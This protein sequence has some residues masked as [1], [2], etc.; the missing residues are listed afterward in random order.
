MLKNT[1]FKL[2][3]LLTCVICAGFCLWIIGCDDDDDDDDDD[4]G[5]SLS[6]SEQCDLN[7]ALKFYENFYTCDNDYTDCMIVC[8]ANDTGCH[9]SCNTDYTD[10]FTEIFEAGLNCTIKCDGCGA[11]YAGLKII[12]AIQPVIVNIPTGPRTGIREVPS[13][14]IGLF[15]SS[16]SSR[17]P[18]RFI[19]VPMRFSDRV[20]MLPFESMMR[21]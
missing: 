13:P 3:F 16:N 1:F 4:S 21:T 5:S 18:S 10:C 8:G 19:I 6:S 17:K 2:S 9:E 15:S 20:A 7:C 11:I 12:N 14:R